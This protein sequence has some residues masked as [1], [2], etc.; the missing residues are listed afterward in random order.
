MPRSSWR[1]LRLVSAISG[2]PEREGLAPHIVVA[3]LDGKQ[4]GIVDV[5]A[6]I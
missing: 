1:W 2:L 4:G 5:G 6:R 3:I